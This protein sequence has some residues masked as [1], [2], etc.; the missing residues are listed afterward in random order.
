MANLEELFLNIFVD[1]YFS[2]RRFVDGNTLQNDIINHMPNLNQFAFSI[3]SFIHLPDSSH[4]PSN[5]DIQRTFKSLEDYQIVSYIDYLPDDKIGYHIYS[6]PYTLNSFCR[7]TNN[8]PGGYFPFVDEISL[9]DHRPFEHEFFMRIAQAFAFLRRLTVD[10]QSPQDQQLDRNH[11]NL[12]MIDYT[13]LTLLDVEMSHYNYVE[14]FLDATKTCLGN[15]IRLIVN[16]YALQ[17]VTNNFTSDATRINCAKVKY[18]DG[19]KRWNVPSH[20]YDYFP[21]LET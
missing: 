21:L 9:R 20:F 19:F 18:L 4:L 16:Y 11:C 13:H 12:S 8:F 14:Q 7:L 6:Y 2:S 10:N 1:R 5:D 15:S 17:I 3:H